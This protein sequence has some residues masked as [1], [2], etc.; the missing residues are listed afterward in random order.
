MLISVMLGPY[1]VESVDSDRGGTRP[2][3]LDMGAR[4]PGRLRLGGQMAGNIRVFVQDKLVTPFVLPSLPDAPELHFGGRVG[5][6]ARILTSAIHRGHGLA[7]L[8]AVFTCFCKETSFYR[9]S[10]IVQHAAQPTKHV[11]IWTDR[12]NAVCSCSASS[13]TSCHDSEN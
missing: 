3:H 5:S 13:K 9:A 11:C 2:S 7:A 8:G 1:L 6:E 10:R 12:R 4:W